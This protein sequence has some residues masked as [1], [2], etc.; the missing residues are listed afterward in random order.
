M[1]DFTTSYIDSAP[2]SPITPQQAVVDKSGLIGLDFLSRAIDA[3]AST[4]VNYLENQRKI[5]AQQAL[6][7]AVADFATTQLKLADAVDQGAMSSQEARMRMRKN[8]T[9]AIA[10]NPA[11]AGELAKAQKDIVKNTGFGKIVEEGTDQEQIQLAAEKEATLAGWIKPHQDRAG[12]EQSVQAYLQFKR[13][14]DMLAQEQARVSLETAKINQGTALY[15][16]QSSRIGLMQKERAE[17]SRVALGSVADAYGYK[18]SQDLDEIKA[19]VDRNELSREEAVMLADQ[20][21]SVLQ[22]ATASIGA[23]AGGDYISNLTAPMKSRYDNMRKFLTGEMSAQVLDNQNQITLGLQKANLLGDPEVAKVV[24][25]SNLL[26]NASTSLLPALDKA[27]VGIMNKQSNPEGKNAD[28]TPDDDEGKRQVKAYLDILKD[29]MKG[30]TGGTLV[31]KGVAEPEI[32]TNISNV[33]KSV[34]AYSM[35]V[36]NPAEYNQI[37][38]FLASPEFGK[39]TTTRGGIPADAAHNAKQVL[40]QQYEQQVLPLLRNRYE[41]VKVGGTGVNPG[42]RGGGAQFESAATVIKP[43][44]TGAGVSFVV[45]PE[46]AKNTRAKLEAQ[47][48]NREVAPVLNRL[49]RMSAHLGGTQDYKAVYEQNYAE[50]FGEELP[51]GDANENVQ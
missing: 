49:I 16:R 39:Y 33:L 43:L 26:P 21:F 30:A 10:N 50:I 8:Y 28:L 15:N 5:E 41:D 20:Q 13:S 1:A 9:E 18:F 48:L 3:G 32:D 14:Q 24:A 40:Q 19:R 45:N 42:P 37:V 11:L 6:D 29:N 7:S 38:D 25:T 34:D 17:R 47:S 31:N 23:D 46:F 4:T 27:V 51:Q 2:S 36:E 35:T 12:R 44:F 22:Q